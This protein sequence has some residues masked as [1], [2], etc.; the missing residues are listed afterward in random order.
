MKR[1][2]CLALLSFAPFIQGFKKAPYISLAEK[3]KQADRAFLDW[4]IDTPGSHVSPELQAFL[5]HDRR[6]F[7]INETQLPFTEYLSKEQLKEKVK[8]IR[9]TLEEGYAAKPMPWPIK[10]ALQKHIMEVLAPEYVFQKDSQ[11]SFDLLDKNY[12]ELLETLSQYA[13]PEK[14]S[15][16]EW[17][18]SFLTSESQ[19]IALA[20][21]RRET[22]RGKSYNE[23]SDVEQMHLLALAA[24]IITRRFM[25][26]L[27]A[28]QQKYHFKEPP[29]VEMAV[30][31]RINQFLFEKFSP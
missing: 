2:L 20:V 23:L 16:Y 22:I 3:N 5:N 10:R 7:I 4:L 31:K 27:Q 14:T 17:A 30:K 1:F 15:L 8:E 28:A 6:E 12:N 19:Y 29:F 25:N 26:R 21:L 24:E 9:K 11:Q 18:L 13:T